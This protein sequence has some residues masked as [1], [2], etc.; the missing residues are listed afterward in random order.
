MSTPYIMRKGVSPV[1]DLRGGASLFSGVGNSYRVI[2]TDEP[3]YDQF[4]ADHQFEHSDGSV[5]VHTTIQSALD[6]A[7][8]GR[9]DYVFVQPSDSDYDI[10]AA[11]TLSKKSVH[12]IGL[13]AGYSRGCGNSV[14]LHQTGSFAI[15]VV[16][17]S[18]IEISGFYLKNFATKGGIIIAN[19]SYGLNIHHNYWAM[20]LSGAT[21]EPMLGP[22]IS[23][24]NGDA[25][26]WSTFERNF[27][28]SQAGASATIAAI[29]RFNA[30]A[31]GIRIA[32]TDVGIGD[33]DNTA[34]V[35]ISN[36]SV[37]GMVLDCNFFAY[38]TASGVGVFTHCI[39]THASGIAYG[40]R[41]NVADGEIVTGGTNEFS[42]ILNY[43]SVA[44]GTQDE[45]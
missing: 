8:E 12:L 39:S 3:Y 18:A 26:A 28:Q 24:T 20:N 16:S 45:L 15:M 31:T 9:N 36:G 40:N 25:G 42:H 10:T 29:I 43:N 34:T 44:G 13:D 2:K 17:D 6:A 22:Y 19:S 4:I 37:K 27:F 5:A 30:Q 7:V 38:Q 41:G 21:N 35:G 14:R 32:E 23:N 1:S 33:T 11:L